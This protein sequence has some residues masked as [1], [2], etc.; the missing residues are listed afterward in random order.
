MARLTHP[1]NGKRARIQSIKD[2][3]DNAAE[4]AGYARKCGEEVRAAE[5]DTEADRLSDQIKS[6]SEEYDALRED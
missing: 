3:R 1:S 4:A 6:E 2:A 5:L